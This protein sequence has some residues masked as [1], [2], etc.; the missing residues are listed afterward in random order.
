MCFYHLYQN[1]FMVSFS[2]VCSSAL[3][4][5]FINLTNMMNIRDSIEEGH[6]ARFTQSPWFYNSKVPQQ[7]CIFGDLLYCSTDSVTHFCCCDL[8]WVP[9][10]CRARLPAVLPLEKEGC[11]DERLGSTLSFMGLCSGARHWMRRSLHF[12]EWSISHPWVAPKHLI[13]M[14]EAAK[15]WEIQEIHLIQCSGQ[16]QKQHNVAPDWWHL[17]VVVLSE[18]VVMQTRLLLSGGIH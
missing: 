1:V 4:L 3:L 8:S 17:A 6:S 5:Q 16:S 10:H 13:M 7:N 9:R 14:W 18:M 12:K 11:K 15:S 2:N